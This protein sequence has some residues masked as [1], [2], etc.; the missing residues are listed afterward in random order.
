MDGV[1]GIDKPKGITSFDVVARMRRATG[2]RRIGHA[3]TLDP[4]AVGVLVLCL[5][6]ATRISSYLME[7]RKRYSAV[8]S[9][10]RSTDTGDSSGSTVEEMPDME[11]PSAAFAEALKWFRGRITQRTPMY[12]AVKVGGRK[13]YE[14]ARKGLEVE[15]PD[16]TVEIY[17]LEGA[18]DG[19]SGKIAYGTSAGIEVECS[20]GT[21]IRTLC[22][23]IGKALGVP[24]H[25]S[26]LRRTWS[27]GWAIDDCIPLDEAES[28]AAEGRSG[29]FM[30]SIEAALPEMRKITLDG[31]EA[32]R[33]MNGSP[34]VVV[35]P[36]GT[37]E[38]MLLGPDGRALAIASIAGAGGGG[39]KVAKPRIVFRVPEV[40][41]IHDGK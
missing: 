37:G 27:S 12:S 31:A 9:F 24:S 30:R 16:R 2:E 20:H 11:V 17:S 8:I 38:A 18:P 7:G 28:M 19:A 5:G 14:L 34:T 36:E 21:Y 4:D 15:R 35:C 25:M 32:S 6:S 13:L 26:A 10:G 3:G 40:V 23:D 41:S 29:E 1:I 39:S 33:V 22:E